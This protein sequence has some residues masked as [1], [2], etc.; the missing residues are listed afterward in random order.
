MSGLDYTVIKLAKET[1]FCAVDDG[2]HMILS[3]VG[4]EKSFSFGFDS[5]AALMT[6]LT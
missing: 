6:K 2:Y 3:S 1:G 4:E 5:L